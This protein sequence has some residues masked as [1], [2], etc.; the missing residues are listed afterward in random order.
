MAALLPRP[1]AGTTFLPASLTFDLPLLH[2]SYLFSSNRSSSRN[3]PDP[4]LVLPSMTV[5]ASHSRTSVRFRLVDCRGGR[6]PHHRGGVWKA[7]CFSSSFF[8][9]LFSI[10]H[11]LYTVYPSASLLL[12]SNPFH[13][14][15]NI[16]VAYTLP[17]F[18][19]TSPLQYA[20]IHFRCH[21][22]GHSCS[23]CCFCFCVRCCWKR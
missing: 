19:P 16:G 20:V 21:S 4:L 10:A 2:T 3:F 9:F 6:G 11:P 7:I 12:A 15:S 1:N 14:F 8:L 23:F 13:A 18:F 17:H 5:M 22:P